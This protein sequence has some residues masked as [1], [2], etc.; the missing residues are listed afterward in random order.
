MARAPINGSTLRW[1][2]ETMFV[3]RGELA[4]AAHTSEGRIAEF[5]TGDARPTLRQ[6]EN[7]ANKLDRTLAFFLQIRPTN[8]MFR[9][10][11]ISVRATGSRFRPC[12]PGRCVEPNSIAIR[13]SS[14]RADPRNPH[15]RSE[16][17][18]VGKECR[19]RW[20]PYH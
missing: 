15:R 5:E 6:L 8:R 11:P 2:R 4:R 17:R 20:S 3:E 7:I 19:S 12:S 1:A 10:P 14:L 18:R 13:C 9:R 16:E